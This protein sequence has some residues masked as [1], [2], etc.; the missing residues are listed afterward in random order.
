MNEEAAVPTGPRTRPSRAG[1]TLPVCRV[2]GVGVV[3]RLLALTDGSSQRE[4]SLNHPF[5][6]AVE[7]RLAR[8]GE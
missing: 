2:G 6:V 1:L 3:E 5:L 8:H 4:V 7:H